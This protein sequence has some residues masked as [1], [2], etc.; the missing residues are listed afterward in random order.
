MVFHQLDTIYMIKCVNIYKQDKSFYA[1]GYQ[2][3]KFYY[4][5]INAK[6]LLNAYYINVKCKSK[7]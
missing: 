4:A 2:Q 3:S 1:P 6:H 5:G 7:K